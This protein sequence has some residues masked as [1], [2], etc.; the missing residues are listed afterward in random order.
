MSILRERA[1][2][3]AD[4]LD[5]HAQ[6]SAALIDAQLAV[7]RGIE[8]LAE[9][10][11]QTEAQVQALNDRLAQP[12][13]AN[14]PWG[15]GERSG[16]RWWSGVAFRG[17]IP[18]L[19]AFVQ[20][21]RAGVKI[22]LVQVFSPGNAGLND[23]WEHIAGGPGDDPTKLDGTL[24]MT[25][26]SKQAAVIWT[27]PL[28]GG[29]PVAYTI[30]PIPSCASNEDGKNPAVWEEIAK[31]EHDSVYRMLGRRMAHLDQKHNRTAPLILEIGHEC[32]GGWYPHSIEGALPDG[33][34]VWQIF[35][36]AWARIVEG[37]RQGY[38][39]L[40]GKYC[41]YLFVFRPARGVLAGGVRLDRY[42]PPPGTWD[43]I[44]LSQHDNA[45]MCSAANPRACWSPSVRKDGTVEMEGL[46]LLA[47]IADRHRRAI[48]IFEWAGYPPDTA[49][50]YPGNPEGE[51]FVA[52]FWDFC[53]THSHLIAAECYFDRGA[54]GFAERP[55]WSA[56]IAYRARWGAPQAWV[57]GAGA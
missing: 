41:P 32:S 38:L 39:S 11:D 10:V 21:P 19:L 34:F 7:H 8:L 23:S 44:G 42:L 40:G 14:G 13:V 53:R 28:T 57:P 54:T 15:P 35:P 3:L 20:G 18:P 30:R 29:L 24:T 25:R 9:A 56:S 36:G 37:I 2:A 43:A 49:T 5:R 33:R 12:P 55:D 27:D 17:T 31:G 6:A 48:A 22:D 16:H 4:V 47:E 1:S 50:V 45:P 51:R 46:L 52:A 26:G